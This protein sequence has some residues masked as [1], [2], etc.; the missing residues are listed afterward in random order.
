MLVKCVSGLRIKSVQS[1]AGRE[2]KFNAR[3]KRKT[4]LKPLYYVQITGV[5]ILFK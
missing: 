4:S 5:L 1:R 3:I 2:L